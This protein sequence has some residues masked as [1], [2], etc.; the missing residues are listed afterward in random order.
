MGAPVA[1]TAVALRRVGCGDD[2]EQRRGKHQSHQDLPY[3][4][5]TKMG[6]SMPSTRLN[7]SASLTA[8]SQ[9]SGRT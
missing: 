2:G 6:C 4:A 5:L 3:A 7:A 8:R 9:S 1:H